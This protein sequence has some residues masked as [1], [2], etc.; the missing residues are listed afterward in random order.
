MGFASLNPSYAPFRLVQRDGGVT[1]APNQLYASF[2]ERPADFVK[3]NLP[4]ENLKGYNVPTR[5]S[6]GFASL[7]LDC[8]L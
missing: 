6:Y 7:P 2:R 3:G 4:K 8:R 1:A 5:G